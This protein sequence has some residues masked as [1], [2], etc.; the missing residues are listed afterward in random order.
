MPGGIHCVGHAGNFVAVL[1]HIQSAFGGDFFT[2]FGH[3]T[4]RMRF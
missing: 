4:N 3:K 1:D 2:A